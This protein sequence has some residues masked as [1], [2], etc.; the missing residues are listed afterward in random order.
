MGCLLRDHSPFIQAP[1]RISNP[2]LNPEKF[3]IIIMTTFKMSLFI[4]KKYCQ[5]FKFRNADAI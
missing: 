4:F 1:F 3:G 2:F 5:N